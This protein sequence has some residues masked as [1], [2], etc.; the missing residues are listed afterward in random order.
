MNV[1]VAIKRV[2]IVNP[3]TNQPEGRLVAVT[4]Q[5]EAYFFVDSEESIRKEVET[6][7]REEVLNRL[8][9]MANANGKY[10]RL[11]GETIL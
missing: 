11:G 10:V 6:F 3:I 4:D 5:D 8:I 2:E 1:Y 7:S 9:T